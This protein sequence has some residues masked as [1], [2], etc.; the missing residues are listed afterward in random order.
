MLRLSI[1][2]G[3]CERVFELLSPQWETDS[4][5]KR[6]E[7]AVTKTFPPAAQKA[8]LHPRNRHCGGY[9]FTVLAA[10]CPPLAP[11]VRLTPAGTPSVDFASPAAVTQLNRTLLLHD[12]GL[13]HWDI[14]AG[15]LCP[16]VPGRPDYLHHLADLLASG[17]GGRIPRGRRVMLLDIGVGA[18]C[19]YPII[20][21]HEYGWRFTG[22]DIDSPSLRWAQQIVDMNPSLAGALRLRR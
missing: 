22:S 15:F 21:H 1:A 5:L 4:A 19:I 10:A 11:F 20:G 2:R 12:Y 16:P 17:N 6:H 18:N 7:C 13:R 9:D 8:A 3:W 14:P